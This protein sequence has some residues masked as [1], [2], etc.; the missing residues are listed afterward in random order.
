MKWKTLIEI[1]KHERRES[2]TS[3][4]DGQQLRVFFAMANRCDVHAVSQNEF[5]IY[6]HNYTTNDD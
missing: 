6:E 4:Y 1:T 3:Q 5:L 2:M